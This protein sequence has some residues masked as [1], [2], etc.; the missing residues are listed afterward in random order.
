MKSDTCKQQVLSIIFR[1]LQQCTH[2]HL[3][4]FPTKLYGT[5]FAALFAF[6]FQVIQQVSFSFSV[7]SCIHCA[8]S[9]CLFKTFSFPPILSPCSPPSIHLSISDPLTL[10][11][12]LCFHVDFVAEGRWNSPPAALS[13]NTCSPEIMVGPTSEGLWGILCFLPSNWAN[14]RKLF[15]LHAGL[16][17]L[18]SLVS[19]SLS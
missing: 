17:S 7:S 6:C 5:V 1:C 16:F 10:T 18:R 19:V 8:L 14:L 2:R 15:S 4:Y 12:H 13:W 9:L 3:I 11:P